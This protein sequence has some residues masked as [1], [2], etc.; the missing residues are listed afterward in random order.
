MP[1]VDLLAPMLAAAGPAPGGGV[2]G[3]LALPPVVLVGLLLLAGALSLWLWWGTARTRSGMA[4]RA[5]VR[6][7]L[8]R[9]TL[10]RGVRELRPSPLASERRE[11]P[12]WQVI[13]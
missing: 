7:T 12:T 5:Q 1:S 10:S 8:G 3:G 6:R 9:A 2:A 4:S 11:R 13:P